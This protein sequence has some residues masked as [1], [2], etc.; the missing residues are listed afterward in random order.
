MT[1]LKNTNQLRHFIK[2]SLIILLSIIAALPAASQRSYVKGIVWDEAIQGAVEGAT[3][4]LNKLPDS[5]FVKGII[6]DMK[7]SFP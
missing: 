4:R 5:T 1:F 7:G 6:T 3:I 2:I